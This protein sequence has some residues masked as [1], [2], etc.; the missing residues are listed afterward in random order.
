MGGSAVIPAPG[1]YFPLYAAAAIMRM[2]WPELKAAVA[3]CVACPLHNWTIELASG[4]A[5][6]PDQGCTRAFA[7]RIDDGVVHVALGD[8]L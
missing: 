8:T 7:V 6:A 5:V 4:C 3:G 2:E 1:N